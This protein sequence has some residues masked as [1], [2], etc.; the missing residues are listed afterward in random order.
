M[1]GG[2]EPQFTSMTSLTVLAGMVLQCLIQSC[3]SVSI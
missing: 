3:P 1:E 2:K